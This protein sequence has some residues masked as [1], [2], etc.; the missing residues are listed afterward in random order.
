MD[1]AAFRT[2][3]GRKWHLLGEKKT[4]RK[5]A[6]LKLKGARANLRRPPRRF[7]RPHFLERYCNFA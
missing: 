2:E 1:E 7:Q 3:N 6:L 4:K 5:M